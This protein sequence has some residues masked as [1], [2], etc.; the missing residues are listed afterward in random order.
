MQE[1]R[2]GVGAYHAARD[3]VRALIERRRARQL[4]PASLHHDHVLEPMPP[5]ASRPQA[6]GPMHEPGITHEPFQHV[7]RRIPPFVYILARSGHVA[8]YN[9]PLTLVTADLRVSS[10]FA[11]MM[12]CAVGKRWPST[13]P[14]RDA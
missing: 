4:A 2:G 1:A 7:K 13:W 10:I 12:A 6:S 3:K 9:L 11:P 14:P 5:S 8:W